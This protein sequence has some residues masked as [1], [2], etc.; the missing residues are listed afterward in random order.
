MQELLEN[1]E[2][3]EVFI[4][5]GFLATKEGFEFNKNYQAVHGSQGYFRDTTIGK[6]NGGV[7]IGMFLYESLYNW[8]RNRNDVR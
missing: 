7:F 2:S 5:E 1:N 4:E 6:Y 3:L 8:Y